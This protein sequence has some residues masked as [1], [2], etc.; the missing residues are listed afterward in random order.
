M[1]IP[2]PFRYPWYTI[3]S[4]DEIQQGDIFNACPVFWPRHVDVYNPS[5]GAVFDW[6][7]RDVIVMTQSCDLMTDR[8]KVHEVPLCALWQ[9]SELQGTHIATP[10]GV[11]GASRPFFL[12]FTC[13]RQAPN[14]VLS[15]TFESR[16]SAAC[17][18]F[19]SLLTASL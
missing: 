3:V 2:P 7:E 8:P 17:I 4:S 5:A 13:W 14:L 16:I 9:Q 11:G 15:E 10:K 1:T 18:R 19:L 6:I 12:R